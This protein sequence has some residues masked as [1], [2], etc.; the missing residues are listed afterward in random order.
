MN[1]IIGCINGN[2]TDDKRCV[3][4]IDFASGR[5]IREGETFSCTYCG[6]EW[7]K[8]VGMSVDE[9]SRA[10]LAA[11]GQKHC[12]DCLSIQPMFS[13]D[14]CAECVSDAD[15][16]AEI[17]RVTMVLNVM[18]KGIM[19]DIIEPG[20]AIIAGM[21]IIRREGGKY[22][23]T[24]DYLDIPIHS[25]PLSNYQACARW[26]ARAYGAKGKLTVHM[27]RDGQ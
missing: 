17:E 2:N 11:K 24:A 21:G 26:M 7:I 12:D 23:A 19:V 1:A 10:E 27:H 22:T 6:D 8:Y 25:L 5:S 4:H 9:R 13:G 18:D 3:Q 14:K 15:D 16:A 20:K